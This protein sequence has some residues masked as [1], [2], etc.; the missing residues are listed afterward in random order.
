MF[1]HPLEPRHHV[2][3]EGKVAGFW[4]IRCVPAA[5]GSHEPRQRR[6]ENFLVTITN[7]QDWL[8]LFKTISKLFWLGQDKLRVHM[9]T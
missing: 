7:G 4:S 2:G 9:E 8:V 6:L 5:V 3:E 1:P